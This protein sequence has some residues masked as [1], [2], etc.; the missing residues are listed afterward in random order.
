MWLGE[1]F[2]SLMYSAI[3]NNAEQASA[4]VT[5]PIRVDLMGF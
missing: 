3:E 4:G 1:W 5:S 2:Q